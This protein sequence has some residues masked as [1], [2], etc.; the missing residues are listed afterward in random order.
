MIIDTH[1][2]LD[3]KNFRKDLDAVVERAREAG[4]ERIVTIGIDLETTE[5]AISLARKYGNVHATAGIHPHEADSATPEVLEKL[6]ELARA[7]EVV[8][9]GE[10]GMD[11][12]R[13]ETT[14]EDQLA[15]FT[16][17]MAL[18]EKLKLPVV[19][20]SRESYDDVAGVLESFSGRV[21]GIIHCMSGGADFRDRALDMGYY[22]AIGGPVTYKANEELRLVIRG[23]PLE[24]L[25]L[26]TDAPFLP[27]EKMRPGRNEP[28]FLTEV[29]RELAELYNVSAEEIERHTSENAIRAF[30]LPGASS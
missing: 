18:A 10:C 19:I 16:A 30:N 28:A 13:S 11:Y 20:H 6:D 24:R 15:A 4:V 17:Q 2:H 7:D 1:A 8:A 23:V 21:K 12:V 5:K 25:L 26:E 29:V 9:V 3:F 14:R 27:P 22:I